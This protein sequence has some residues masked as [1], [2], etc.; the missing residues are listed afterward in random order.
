MKK[1]FNPA[2]QVMNRLKCPQKF[3]LVGLLM[4]IP[5]L[6][7]MTQFLSK[8]NED[9]NFAAKERI[10]LIYTTPLLNFL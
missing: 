6:L 9:I 4:P 10:G 1:F 2:T 5:L 7:L 8:I 3:M